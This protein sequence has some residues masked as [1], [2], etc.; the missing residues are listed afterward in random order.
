MKCRTCLLEK[1]GSEFY[2]DETEC[3]TCHR[4][5][6]NRNRWKKWTGLEYEKIQELRQKQD[7]VCQ[8]CGK[9][10]DRKLVVDHCHETNQFRGLICHSCN[11]GIGKLGDCLEGVLKAVHYLKGE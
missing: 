6:R 2:K 1:K 9:T 11:K 10:S 5:R 7:R 4:Q 3:K 8:C